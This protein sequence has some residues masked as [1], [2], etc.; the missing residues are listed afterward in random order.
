MNN[1][2]AVIRARHIDNSKE[3]ISNPNTFGAPPPIETSLG[4]ASLINHPVFY[5]TFDAR[6]A[7]QEIDVPLDTECYVSIWEFK[8]E[9]PIATTF[10][11]SVDEKNDLFGVNNLIPKGLPKGLEGGYTIKSLELALKLRASAFTSSNYEFTSKIA[12]DIIYNNV[13][14]SV[15]LLYPSVV[16]PYRCN[17]ALNPDYVELNMECVRIYKMIWSG[18]FIFRVLSRGSLL[19][20]KIVWEDTGSYE[21]DELDRKYSGGHGPDKIHPSAL[22]VLIQKRK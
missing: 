12:H 19:D 15:A 9:T 7:M 6:T 22:E 8:K 1:S 10:L 17:I 20:N 11:S 16:D 2:W 14:K 13:A 5:G 3:D 4:R 21:R 18:A